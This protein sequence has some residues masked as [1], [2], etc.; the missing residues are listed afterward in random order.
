MV[1]ADHV[2]VHVLVA[3]LIVCP[4]G[5]VLEE[6]ELVMGAGRSRFWSG[7]LNNWYQSL[8]EL[9]SKLGDLLCAVDG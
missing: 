6:H 3:H 2:V 9:L 5:R 7:K 1:T 4:L 8:G